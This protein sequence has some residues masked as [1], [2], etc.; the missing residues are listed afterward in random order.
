MEASTQGKPSLRRVKTASPAGPERRADPA[1]SPTRQAAPVEGKVFEAISKA[2]GFNATM[3]EA[4]YAEKPVLEIRD[5]AL[6]YGAKQALF[7][8]SFP[9]AAGKVTAL[10]GPSGC[11]K[12]TL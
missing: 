1:T 2:E 11:G 12:S 4:V 8:I 6:W 9:V 5:F 3:H 7:S 10:I